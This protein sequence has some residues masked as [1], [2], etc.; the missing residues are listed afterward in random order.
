MTL[1]P[2][3][4]NPRTKH[5]HPRQSRSVWISPISVTTTPLAA[6]NLR[7][8]PCRFKADQTAALAQRTAMCGLGGIGKTQIAVQY[9]YKHCDD[10][11]SV[12]WA[13]AESSEALTSSF[14]EIAVLLDLPAK[15]AQDQTLTVQA[16][17]RWLQDN[18]GWLLIFR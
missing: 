6:R 9:A 1:H 10:Y 14:V 2:L 4:K 18:H 3:M 15:D 12:L 8:A 7:A 5:H 16:V 11:Q 17:R 13:R